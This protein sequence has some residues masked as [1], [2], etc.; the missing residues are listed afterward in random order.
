MEAYRRAGQV[1][2]SAVGRR[3]S[4][5]AS[6]ALL[7]A[8][9]ECSR[10]AGAAVPASKAFEERLFG[11]PRRRPPASSWQTDHAVS[12]GRGPSA[13]GARSQGEASMAQITLNPYLNFNG[14]TRE[15][16]EF[17]HQILGGELTL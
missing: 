17:Y 7:I 8:A 9:R 15:A 1:C 6:W 4:T 10:R 12:A 11:N 13:K 5:R 2:A 3:V 16:L 14:N